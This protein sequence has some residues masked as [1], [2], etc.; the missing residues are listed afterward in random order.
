MAKA[1]ARVLAGGDRRSTGASDSVVDEVAAHPE[2]FEELWKC[3]TDAEPIVRMRAADALEKVTRDHCAWLEPH[4]IKLLSGTLDDG[5][6][7]VRWHLA[8]MSVRPSLSAAEARQ[9]AG[10]LRLLA[11]TDDSRIV[12]VCALQA[13]I[14]LAKRHPAIRNTARGMIAVALRSDVASLRARAKKLA[15]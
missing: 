8:M 10:R 15:I 3:L 12:R 4:K 1:F 11:E 5:T 7:E 6:P 13:V 9:L 2:R 14:D